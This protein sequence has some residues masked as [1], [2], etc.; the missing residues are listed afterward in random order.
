MDPKSG[1]S[2]PISSNAA[3]VDPESEIAGMILYFEFLLKQN[4]KF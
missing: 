4:N 3:T 1:S 2:T